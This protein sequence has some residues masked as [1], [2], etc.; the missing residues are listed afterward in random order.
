M[1]QEKSRYGELLKS[2]FIHLARS[3]EQA[4]DRGKP[5]VHTYVK[6]TSFSPSDE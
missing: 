3:K 4:A 2:L 6:T 1:S 5:G